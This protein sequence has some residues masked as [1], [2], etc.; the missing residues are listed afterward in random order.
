MT[1]VLLRT[2]HVEANSRCCARPEASAIPR[3]VYFAAK[4]LDRD[5]AWCQ[6]HG[7][8]AIRLDARNT[9]ASIVDFLHGPGYFFHWYGH[10]DA[11]DGVKWVEEDDLGHWMEAQKK[12]GRV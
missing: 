3:Q 1:V 5:P 11:N 4:L 6:Q 8:E 10:E 9:Y 2:D 7:I 12:K